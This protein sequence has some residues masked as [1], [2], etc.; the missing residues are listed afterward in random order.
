MVLRRL[1]QEGDE[2][3]GQFFL[4][5][6][7]VASGGRLTDSALGEPSRGSDATT[8]DVK[9][10]KTDSRLVA[11]SYLLFL[12]AR[13][14]VSYAPACHAGGH[15]FESRRSRQSQNSIQFMGLG[16]ASDSAGNN[17]LLRMQAQG[18]RSG[19]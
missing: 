17:D 2:I 7:K 4:A 5:L 1:L 12:R 14:Q 19:D 3:H 15:G 18:R 10:C 16:M 6:D 9:H 13:Q 11:E 8:R